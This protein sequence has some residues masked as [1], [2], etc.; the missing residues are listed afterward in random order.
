M[1]ADHL[2]RTDSLG[3]AI[4]TAPNEW[5]GMQKSLTNDHV[6]F[7]SPDNTK[8]LEWKKKSLFLFFYLFFCVWKKS[9]IPNLRI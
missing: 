6:F 8:F 3:K 4:A 2:P 9:G 1:H 7:F 5:P